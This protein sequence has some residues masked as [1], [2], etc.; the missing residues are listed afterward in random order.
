MRIQIGLYR[1]T[2]THSEIETQI[3]IR[4]YSPSRTA[5]F[6]NYPVQN[7]RC[8]HICRAYKL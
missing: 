7:R 3:Q 8:I 5:C 4:I 2:D 6:I 1:E